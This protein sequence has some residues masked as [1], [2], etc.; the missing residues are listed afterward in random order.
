[1]EGKRQLLKPKET[2]SNVPEILEDHLLATKFFLLKNKN[3][4][5]SCSCVGRTFLYYSIKTRL[6]IRTFGPIVA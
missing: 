5:C 2:T 6:L 1:M 4:I 3:T